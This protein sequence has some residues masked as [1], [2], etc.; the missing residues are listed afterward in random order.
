MISVG[1]DVSRFNTMIISSMPRNIAEYI[2][3]SSR[4][5]RDE[6]GIVFTVHHPFR[7]RDI[8]HYQKF[9][10]FHEK[11]YSYVEPISVTPFATKALDRYLAMFCATIL[12]HNTNLGL[13]NN[14]DA[15]NNITHQKAIIKK[16]VI[17]EIKKVK[18]NAEKLNHYLLNREEGIKS[19]IVGIIEN[20]EISDLEQKIE[21]LI[22]NWIKRLDECNK[23]NPQIDLKYRDEDNPLEALFISIADSNYPNHWKVSHSLR[24]IDPS[25]VIKTVQQ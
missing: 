17:D 9:K 25:T 5:A 21:F 16:I 7:S 22:N 19:N 6:K 13:I 23:T 20:D 12:R 15:N 18:E 4:V 3:A 2:Q 11:F 10:E 14:D 8:S 1:I 24:E